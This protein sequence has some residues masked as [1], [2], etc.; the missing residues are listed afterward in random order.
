MH[1]GDLAALT[2]FQLVSRCIGQQ[3]GARLLRVPGVNITAI[4]GANRAHR[5]AVVVAAA[6]RTA[7]IRRGG[8]TVGL[9]QEHI[10]GRGQTRAKTLKQVGIAFWRHGVRRRTRRECF[11]VMPALILGIAATYPQRHFGPGV[12][13]FQLAVLH[14][15]VAANPVQGVEFHVVWQVAPAGCRPMP[16]G[17]ADQFQHARTKLERADVF[18][19]LL[20]VG[21]TRP[22]LIRVRRVVVTFIRR[23]AE[24]LNDFPA[25]N[26]LTG[27]QN[28]H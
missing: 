26:G 9:M 12:I 23:V 8:A 25:G 28:N 16:G 24:I 1:G 18:Y 21:M 15:P 7:V 11:T 17:A 2:F 13:G 6:R 3:P 27:F 19:V 20:V 14:R 4:H 22:W 10:A 5:H